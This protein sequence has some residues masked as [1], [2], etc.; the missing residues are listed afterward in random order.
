M[1]GRVFGDA[2]DLAQQLGADA[3]AADARQAVLQ[4]RKLVGLA[5]DGHQ[6]DGHARV[7]AIQSVSAFRSC[8]QK[9]ASP[10]FCASSKLC[11]L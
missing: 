3:F 5:V 6:R 1:G 11:S 9:S 10:R 4:G 7:V 8:A 2:G